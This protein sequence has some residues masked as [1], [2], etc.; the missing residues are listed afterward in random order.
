[1]ERSNSIPEWLTA[2]GTVGATAV[3]LALGFGLR[4]WVFRPHLTL[5]FSPSNIWDQ[6][7]TGTV[8]G[9][10]AAFVRLRVG[11]GGRA[12]AKGVR[13]SLLLVERWTDDHLWEPVR[14][15]LA[16][17]DLTWS[18]RPGESSRD[19]PPKSERPLDLF[20]IRRDF[21]AQ[22]EI[23]AGLQVSRVVP[24]NRSDLLTPGSW[25]V[26]LEVA[27]D[28]ATP[29][30]Y[31]VAFRFDGW[32]PA[33]EANGQPGIW[34]AVAV[35][36]PRTYPPSKPPTPELVAPEEMLAETLQEPPAE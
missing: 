20:E 33:D 36:G 6:V 18:N 9:G 27:A 8:D 22:G 11:N 14:S 12:L 4:E 24:A 31:W 13:V 26:K 25:L 28:N 30:V 3:A 23:P 10:T 35:D 2:I 7:V 1:M 16:G 15:E 32:W 17:S 19:V 34:K 21:N 5:S 29:E